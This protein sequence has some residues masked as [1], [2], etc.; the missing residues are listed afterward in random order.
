ME[1]EFKFVLESGVQ[2]EVS[3]EGSFYRGW[4]AEL[5]ESP[6]IELHF[7]GEPF[8]SQKDL[9]Q[10]EAQAIEELYQAHKEEYTL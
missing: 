9:D 8:I 2:I 1:V 4:D 6:S 7:E 5:K 3:A 10:I